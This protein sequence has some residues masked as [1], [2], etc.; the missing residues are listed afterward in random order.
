LTVKEQCC[1]IFSELLIDNFL[2]LF[3]RATFGL[4]ALT[5]KLTKHKTKMGLDMYLNKRIYIGAN[6]EHN[7]VNVEIKIIKKNHKGEEQEVVIDPKKITYIEERAGYWRKANHIHKWFVDNVMGGEDEC[8]DYSVSA[9]QLLELLKVCE[10]VVSKA[11]MVDG[12]LH[13]STSYQG[14]EKTENYEDGKVIENVEE[15]AELLPTER[16]FFFGST[17][18]NEWYLQDVKDT[19]KIINDLGLTGPD[20]YTN[21]YTYHPS[22]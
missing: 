19:I 1:K 3:S 22:W 4:S 18:Y 6:Y 9:E 8:K 21:E 11:K 12:R 10:E 17:D 2:G 14:G 7:N 16:G 20:D 15:I 13:T 5:F